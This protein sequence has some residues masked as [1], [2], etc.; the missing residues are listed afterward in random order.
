MSSITASE[1]RA[2]CVTYVDEFSVGRNAVNDVRIGYE[3]QIVACNSARIKNGRIG[4]LVIITARARG[5]RVL[6]IGRLIERA[7]HLRDTWAHH[8]G[9]PWKY[10]WTI[11]PIVPP[12]AVTPHV[13]SEIRRLS[14][15][16]GVS[17]KVIF[18]SRLCPH[19][20]TP[21]L[22]G[23]ATTFGL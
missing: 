13:N 16:Y 20:A 14:T 18:N 21:V 6:M 17:Y 9:T 3:N 7:D 2:H 12:I 8:G 10:C 11:E 15:E 19:R 5:A 22:R 4:D 23:L 1:P